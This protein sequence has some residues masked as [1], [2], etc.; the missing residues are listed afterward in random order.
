VTRRVAD[1]SSE[2]LGLPHASLASSTAETIAPAAPASR[3]A[4]ATRTDT[5]VLLAVGVMLGPQGFAI[6]NAGTLALLDPVVPVALAA[7]GVLTVFDLGGTLGRRAQAFAEPITRG[8][9]A[10]AVVAG[11][12]LMLATVTN[13]LFAATWMTAVALGICAST[14]SAPHAPDEAERERGF[15]ALLPI[16]I[17]GLAIGAWRDGTPQQAT[18]VAV[19]MLAISLLVAGAGWLLL[20]RR[21]TEQEQRVFGAG[22]LLLLGGA[23]DYL[24]SSALLA[25]LAAGVFWRTTGGPASDITR[26]DL[27]H[28]QH[29]LLA[30]VLLVA[31]A[32]TVVS[33]AT[34]ALACAYAVLRTLGVLAGSIAAGAA[35]PRLP[36]PG[37]IGV[38]FALNAA[39][40]GAAEMSVALSAAVLG[41]IGAQL[42]TGM[43]RERAAA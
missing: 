7:L 19:Q 41:T 1:L 27:T 32:Q 8:V 5:S 26:R 4:W 42:L 40:G 13:L 30:L 31:G 15:D 10:A 35:A 43:A 22:T 25:G 21:G 17:G 18:A 2:P 11:G 24:A 3:R 14:S 33:P 29:P 36:S 12:L 16:V 20:D 23:A 28:L 9:V 39:R 34:L 6:L 38:A 37:I